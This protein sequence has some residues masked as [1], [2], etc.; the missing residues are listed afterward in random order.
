[1]TTPH[2]PL[3]RLVSEAVAGVE[4]ADRLDEIRAR[5]A[6]TSTSRRRLFIAGGTVLAAAAAVVAVALVTVVLNQPSA[7][8]TP[9][10]DDPTRVF[11]TPTPSAHAVAAYF[12]GGL[13][14]VLTED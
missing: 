9:P 2:D 5:T 11:D 7:D 8:D 13:Q 1:M 12:V 14:V 3:A 10:T 6:E 4:P